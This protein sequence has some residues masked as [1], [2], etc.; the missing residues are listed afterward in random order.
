MNPANAKSVVLTSIA[1]TGALSIFRRVSAGDVPDVPRVVIG[2]FGAAIILLYA[3]DAAPSL[4]AGIAALILAG[5][6]F[7]NGPQVWQALSNGRL[8]PKNRKPSK[9]PT[10]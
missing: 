4:A 7:G 2:S 1:A 3:S 9:V 6:V 10:P 5:S 8:A